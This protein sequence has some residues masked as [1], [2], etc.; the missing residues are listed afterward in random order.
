MSSFPK[1]YIPVFT[2]VTPFRAEIPALQDMVKDGAAKIHIYGA[3]G[4]AQSATLRNRALEFNLSG[5][6]RSQE[7]EKDGTRMVQEWYG[8]DFAWECQWRLDSKLWVEVACIALF[9]L[10]KRSYFELFKGH[11]LTQLGLWVIIFH[12]EWPEMDAN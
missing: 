11:T 5:S 6:V 7:G 8:W 9:M 12:I 4:K 3:L 10:E 2:E 1:Q